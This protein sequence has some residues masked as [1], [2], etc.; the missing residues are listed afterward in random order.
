MKLRAR[1]LLIVLII[2]VILLAIAVVA[3]HTGR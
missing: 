2:G 1:H 3:G